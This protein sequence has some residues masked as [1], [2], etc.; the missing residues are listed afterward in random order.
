[1]NATHTLEDEFRNPD[2]VRAH[3]VERDRSAKPDDVTASAA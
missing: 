3:A 1:M 2:K